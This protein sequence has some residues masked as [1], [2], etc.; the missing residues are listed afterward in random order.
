M[1]YE[2]RAVGFCLYFEPEDI[3]A[4]LEEIRR[5]DLDY[6]DE[7]TIDKDEKTAELEFED[8]SVIT[9]NVPSNEDGE[10]LEEKLHIHY[11]PGPDENNYDSAENVLEEIN[12]KVE[13]SNPEIHYL[14]VGIILDHREIESL[15][16]GNLTIDEYEVDGIELSEDDL[17][18]GI[19]ET[20]DSVRITLSKS[21]V[22]ETNMNQVKENLFESLEQFVDTP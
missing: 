8:R 3:T 14:T 22:E 6:I 1:D 15:I 12:N 16:P 18:Y 11:H 4:F 13:G 10:E 19:T 9:V 21:K 20:N 17:V 2:S 5:L 7:V